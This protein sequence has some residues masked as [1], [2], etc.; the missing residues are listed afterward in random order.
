M[1]FEEMDFKQQELPDSSLVGSVVEGNK[2]YKLR[3]DRLVE[4]TMTLRVEGVSYHMVSCFTLS[5]VKRN[6]LLFP[7]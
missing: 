4:K 7:A 3:D 1:T 6:K 2:N 5:D